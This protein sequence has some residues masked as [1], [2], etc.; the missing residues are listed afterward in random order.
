MRKPAALTCGVVL[1]CGVATGSAAADG[2]IPVEG[3][4]HATTSAGLPV[5]FQVSV[6]QIVEPR[7]RFRW[8][9]CGMFES[10]GGPPVPIEPTG[11][12][13]YL[14]GQGP[15]IEATFVAPD[16]AEGTVTAPSRMLPGCPETRA[17]FVAE[18]G[19]AKFPEP[20]TVVLAAVGT[21]RYVHAPKKMVLRRDGSLRF[22]G[23][24]WRGFGEPEAHGTG[25][26]YLRKGR[27]VR[28]PRV[29]VTLEELTQ[30]EAGYEEYLL[31]KY[32]LHGAVPP[33]FA[34]RGTRVLE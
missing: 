26:A 32:V 11:H 13:K 4:W 1:A 28:R 17:S 29:T 14:E 31:L 21:R 25:R 9:F 16:R 34:H 20:K 10:E 8:G 5:G 6:G 30:V 24:H 23:L 18:P 19:A 3:P 15:Y 27:V 7:F 2:V 12:W 33:G 22:Y